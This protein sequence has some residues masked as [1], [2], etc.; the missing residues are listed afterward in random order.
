ME[1]QSNVCEIKQ[2]WQS[3]LSSIQLNQLTSHE[4]IAEVTKRLSEP[5]ENLSR[6]YVNKCLELSMYKQAIVSKGNDAQLM[7]KASIDDLMLLKSENARLREATENKIFEQRY[8]SS[9]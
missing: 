8:C 9:H 3:I 5:I 1:D 6:M 4:D 2:T 7:L